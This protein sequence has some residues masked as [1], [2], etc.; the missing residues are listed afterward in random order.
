MNY[1]DDYGAFFGRLNDN[2]DVLILHVADGYRAT[3]LAANVYPVGSD[4]SA[5]HE[6]PEGITLSVTDAVSL[7]IEIEG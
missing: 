6:H 2:G 4:L 5:R 3:R 1:T 7:G